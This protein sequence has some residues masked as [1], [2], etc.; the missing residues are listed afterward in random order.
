MLKDGSEGS[1]YQ[2]M[3]D[4]R[5]LFFL[6]RFSFLFSSSDP[7]DSWVLLRFREG[8][9]SSESLGRSTCGEFGS[10][11]ALDSS[12]IDWIAMISVR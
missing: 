2:G 7:S 5:S 3:S 12:R 4:S 6:I 9:F 10:L 11:D 8:I 1:V